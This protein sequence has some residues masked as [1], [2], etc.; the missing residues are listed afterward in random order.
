MPFSHAL[1]MIANA[2]SC[3]MPCPKNSGAEPTPPKLP[4]PSSGVP[5][6]IP[7]PA[8]AKPAPALPA[9]LRQAYGSFREVHP[10]QLV[11]HVPELGIERVVD[12]A[13]HYLDGRSLGADHVCAD[14][15]LHD[16]EVPDAPD[17]HALV[18]LDQLLGERVE[19]LELPAPCV[20]LDE[21]Q[22][23]PLVRGVECLSERLRDAADLAEAGR[24]EAAA[25]TEHLAH[26]GVL[27]RRHVLEHVERRGDELQA[28]TRT[29]QE[30]IGRRDVAGGDEPARLLDLVP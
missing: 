1:S 15:A 19:I 4:Q 5:K 2:S 30:P 9:R 26:L 10:G 17:N 16:L 21:R 22:P 6:L 7:A 29:A 20:N 11:P 14:H 24:V 3:S 18:E 13:A 28:V 8:P 12:Q 25:G 23:R 27:P